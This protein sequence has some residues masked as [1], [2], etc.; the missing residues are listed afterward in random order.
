MVSIAVRFAGLVTLLLFDAYLTVAVAE[1][2]KG[3]LP[4]ESENSTLSLRN[5]MYRN[6]S[7]AP[8][9]ISIQVHDARNNTVHKIVV[10]NDS[11]A[12]FIAS[13]RKIPKER[14]E[15]FYACDYVEM[16]LHK[17]E[18]PLTLDIERFIEYLARTTFGSTS[19][20][21]KYVRGQVFDV[22]MTFG[23]LDVK[24]E[25]ELIEKYF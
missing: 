11:V 3:L 17:H 1:C 21:Q 20:A 8:S 25:E 22:P 5:E 10:E 2:E 15:A 16:M 9:L 23:E 18:T 6:V 14:L 13:E 19:A 7:T 12:G 4:S 24:N